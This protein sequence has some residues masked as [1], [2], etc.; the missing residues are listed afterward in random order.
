V[1]HLA[2]VDELGELHHPACRAECDLQLEKELA[3]K[4]FGSQEAVGDRLASERDKRLNRMT[5]DQA[6]SHQFPRMRRP[7]R[8]ATTA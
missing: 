8:G 5:A 7:D 4:L 1:E 2:L 6:R 3:G